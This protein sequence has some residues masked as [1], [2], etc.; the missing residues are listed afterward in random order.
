MPKRTK[1]PLLVLLGT[2]AALAIAIPA[3]EGNGRE[4]ES[5]QGPRTGQR[6]APREASTRPAEPPQSSQPATA[7]APTPDTMPTEPP[8]PELP[9]FL[10]IVDR[11]EPGQRANVAVRL[12][13][14]RLIELRTTNVQ[15][16]RIT[17]EELPLARNRSTVL[18]IDDQGIEWTAG[19][20]VVEL[21]RTRSG[22]W[23]IVSRRAENP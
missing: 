10:A 19:V 3:C 13:P 22:A 7:S 18:Q 2:A 5:D 20:Y 8:E 15:R 4:R 14:P 6:T 21:E 9:P 12:D 11:I 23:E 1:R 17:R 16:I